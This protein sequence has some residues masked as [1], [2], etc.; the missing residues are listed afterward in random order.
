MNMDYLKNIQLP[1]FQNKFYSNVNDAKSAPTGQIDLVECLNTGVTYNKLFDNSIMEYD[2]NYNNDQ[3]SSKA[4]L[5][6]MHTIADHLKKFLGKHPNLDVVEIGCGQGLFMKMLEE[7]GISA[8]GYDPSYRGNS[9]KIKKIYFNPN[10]NC[11]G[12]TFFILRHVLEHIQNPFEFLDQIQCAT[13]GDAFA[14]IEV[15]CLEWI[16]KNNAWFD[17]F[18]EHV[19]YFKKNDFMRNYSDVLHCSNTFGDQYISVIVDLKSR[20]LA[21]VE[22]TD[23]QLQN[24]NIKPP[25]G[26]YIVWGAGSKGVIYSLIMKKLYRAPLA[27]V[28]LNIEKKNKYIPISGLK[29]TYYKD[30]LKM[31]RDDL[32][33]V[34]MNPNYLS[35]VKTLTDNRFTYLV[36]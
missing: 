20:R 19:N 31:H 18:Y 35:E 33:V 22:H 6:H 17:I 24:F 16:N 32:N 29:V 26:D 8:D 11:T 15:P 23:T 14:Y 12:D 1:I 21:K 34:V 10:Q 5:R 13:T 30:F 27:I 3:T 36:P 4:F 2:Q 28:D 9:D 7:R 25:N